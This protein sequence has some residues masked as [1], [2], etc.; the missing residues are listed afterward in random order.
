MNTF[1]QRKYELFNPTAISHGNNSIRMR[2]LS[3]K[4]CDRRLYR[5]SLSLHIQYVC[6]VHS[7]RWLLRLAVAFSCWSDVVQ[8]NADS[9]TSPWYRISTLLSYGAYTLWVN[10]RWFGNHLRAL[11]LFLRF[12]CEQKFEYFPWKVY[13]RF[14]ERWQF[15]EK[16][17]MQN[18]LK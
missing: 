18:A 11:R 4:M 2:S 8:I 3:T 9:F 16:T 17:K 7:I 10:L 15:C 14:C 13:C 6:T 1:S 5:R 12:L